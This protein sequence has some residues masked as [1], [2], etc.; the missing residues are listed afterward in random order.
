MSE[1]P[2]EKLLRVCRHWDY[3]STVDAR[4]EVAGEVASLMSFHPGDSHINLSLSRASDE[5]KYYIEE[6]DER[7]VVSDYDNVPLNRVEY[8]DF[9]GKCTVDSVTIEKWVSRD[10]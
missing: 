5:E 4:V 9:T 6:S 8:E 1:G 2:A 3:Y 10:E 7:V